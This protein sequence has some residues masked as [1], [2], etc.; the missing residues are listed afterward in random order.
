MTLSNGVEQLD[1]NVFLSCRKLE[2]IIIP[3]SV[4]RIGK[5]VFFDCPQLTVF[6][7]SGSSA[8]KYALDYKIPF[9]SLNGAFPL[10]GDINADGNIDAQDALM[11]LQHSVGVIR[12][13]VFDAADVDGSGLVDAA[14]A[15]LILQKSVGLIAEFPTAG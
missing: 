2:K 4:K 1:D 3:K 10:P 13:E 5:D 12:L 14:D 7:H 9:E 15:L 6:G 8:E 11:A